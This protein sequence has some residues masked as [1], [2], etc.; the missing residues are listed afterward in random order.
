M[1][2]YDEQMPGPEVEFGVLAKLLYNVGHAAMKH[3][4]YLDTSVYKECKR[5]NTVLEAQKGRNDRVRASNVSVTSSISLHSSA[6]KARR[7]MFRRKD[8]DCTVSTDDAG[9]EALGGAT[10]DDADAEAIETELETNIITGGGLFSLYVPLVTDVCQYPEKYKSHYVQAFGVMALTKMMCI[11]AQF[12]ETHLQLLITILERSAFPEIRGNILMGLADLMTRF[13]T[14]VE[15]W[16][17]H[18]YGRLRDN[19]VTVRSTAVRVIASLVKREMIRVKG[20][21]SEMAL[22]IV[23][24]NEEIRL[25]TKQFFEELSQKGNV[26]YNILPDILSK[27][28]SKDVDVDEDGFHEIVKHILGLLSK[29]R[30]TDALLDKICQRLKMAETD[31]QCRDLAYCLSLLQLGKKGILRLTTNLPLIKNKLY[32]REVQKALKDIIEIARKKVEN[33]EICGQLENDIDKLL[34]NDDEDMDEDREAMPP[35]LAPPKKSAP[36]KKKTKK[37]RSDSSDEEQDE[38]EENVF[39]NEVNTSTRRSSRSK[40]PSSKSSKRK[41]GDLSPEEDNENETRSKRRSNSTPTA[42]QKKDKGDNVR[43]SLRKP[44]EQSFTET[45][46]PKRTRTNKK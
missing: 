46:P 42:S 19:E 40:T 15:P 9:E 12:C 21:M 27:L 23:D 17:S 11:S 38:D 26:L 28:T 2:D 7:S 35:P 1:T 5:R 29:E 18:F 14:Q 25:F 39:R 45:P 22:C 34:D 3:M 33:R 8:P 4:V 32:I 37:K 10:A 16:T 13:P 30:E 44:R 31:R 43:R 6:R 41:T 20:Q 24:E 36:S